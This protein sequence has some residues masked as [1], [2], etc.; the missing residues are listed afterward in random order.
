MRDDMLGFLDALG[1]DRVTL[2][3]HL[4]GGA[5]ALLFAEE[6]ADRIERLVIED[7]PAPFAGGDRVPVRPRPDNPL[8]FDWPRI[9]AIV[10]QLNSPDPAWWDR[11]SD[12]AV[13]TLVIAGGPRRTD[14]PPHRGALWP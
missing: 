9:A 5:V 8:D 11:T 13:P 12:I 10:G 1:L 4:M 7:N 6:H 2:I 3:G 14:A